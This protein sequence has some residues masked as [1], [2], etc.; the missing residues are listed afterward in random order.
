MPKSQLVSFLITIKWKEEGKHRHV[1]VHLHRVGNRYRA[2]MV[3]LTGGE[4]ERK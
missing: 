1:V 3:H 2:N 4:N